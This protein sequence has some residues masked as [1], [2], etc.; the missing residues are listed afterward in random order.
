MARGP[1]FKSNYKTGPIDLVD[2]YP[3][4]LGVLGLQAPHPNNGSWDNVVDMISD[5][6]ENKGSRNPNY[7]SSSS[8]IV[9]SYITLSLICLFKLIINDN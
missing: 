9:F 2:V 8:S 3:L 5:D 4:M 7:N 6:W 1:A